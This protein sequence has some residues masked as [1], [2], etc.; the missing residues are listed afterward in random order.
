M[1]CP[2]CGTWNPEDKDV[3]WRCQTT[4][5]RPVEKKKARAG[6]LCRYAHVVLGSCRAIFCRYLLCPVLFAA[7]RLTVRLSSAPAMVVRGFPHHRLRTPSVLI[8]GVGLGTALSA[9]Q[10][11]SRRTPP[12]PL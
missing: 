10:R 12:R 1:D 3:C 5:P 11:C 8:A 7:H 2:N 9:V 6:S 4:M